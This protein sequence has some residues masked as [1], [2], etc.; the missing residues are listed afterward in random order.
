MTLARATL[1]AIN[2]AAD[3]QQALLEAL[4]SGALHALQVTGNAQKV[5]EL[6]AMLDTFSTQFNLIEP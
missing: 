1:N 5:G 4:Q 6:F 2:T 3:P